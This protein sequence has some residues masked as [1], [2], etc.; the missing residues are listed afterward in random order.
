MKAA[1]S[2]AG[3]EELWALYEPLTPWGRDE[4]E[5]R[6][7]F[8]DPDAIRARHDDIELALA[9]LG[10]AD[11]LARDRMSWYLKRMPRIPLEAKSEYEITELFQLKKFL[12]NYRGARTALGESAAGA[13]R[14]LEAASDLAAAL[15]RGGSDPE[16]FF[17][18]DAYDPG[19]REV[20]ESLDACLERERSERARAEAKARVEKGLSFDGREFLLVPKERAPAS[21]DASYLLEPYDEK[22]YL[23][24]LR[25]SVE[26]LAIAEEKRALL[27]RERE[28]ENRVILSLSKLAAQAMPQLALAVAALTRWDIARAGAVLASGHG[29]VRPD[30]SSDGMAIMEGRN[31]PCEADCGRLGLCYTPLTA[32]FDKPAVV[33]FGSNMGG[34]TVVLKTALFFQ[35]AAQAGLFVPARSFSSRVYGSILYVGEQSGQGQSGLSGFGS[36]VWRLQSALSRGRLTLV[37]Y[38]ELARTTGSHEAEALLSAV[39]E[40]YA[41]GDAGSGCLALFATHFRGVARVQGARYL[42]MMGLDRD[43]ANSALAADQPLE[44]RLAGIN[45]HMRYLLVSDDGSEPELSDA[46]AVASMLGL[47]AGLVERARIFFRGRSRS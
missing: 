37:A 1:W 7:V 10:G 6:E 17:L 34:K 20:R 12:A 30:L 3:M 28:A 5:K 42:R 15:D 46:L 39:V 25:P 11:T 19:L 29:M 45:R 41:S 16:T 43:A 32:V 18:A 35:L 13:F 14:F 4:R 21:D 2:F 36:E 26:A 44:A 24:R 47:D 40:R 31:L 38:D 27:E 9:W 8:T 23:V 33:L 22:R